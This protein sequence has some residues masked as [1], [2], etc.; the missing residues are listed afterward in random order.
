LLASRI[1]Q[2]SGSSSPCE[3]EEVEEGVGLEVPSGR[4]ELVE[5][6]ETVVLANDGVD[7]VVREGGGGRRGMGTLDIEVDLGG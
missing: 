3:E 7:V 4:E 6:G 1:S 2:P 5:R